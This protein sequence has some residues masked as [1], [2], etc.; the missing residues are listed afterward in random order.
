M[1]N[2]EEKLR[3]ILSEML[4]ID[5]SQIDDD[6]SRKQLDSWDSLTHLMLITEIE[7]AFGIFLSDEDIIQIN[8][9]GDLKRKLREKG[10]NIS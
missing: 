5:E 10:V 4:L 2:M 9:V 8:T 3:R 7:S 1:S 6:L